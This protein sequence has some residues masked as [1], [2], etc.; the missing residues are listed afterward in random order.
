M[1][2]PGLSPSSLVP[3][4]VTWNPPPEGTTCTRVLASESAS[5]SSFRQTWWSLSFTVTSEKGA[6]P[7]QVSS[8]NCL[9]SASPFRCPQ[10]FQDAVGKRAWALE[11]DSPKDSWASHLPFRSL[12]FLI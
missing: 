1:P 8:L 2:F 9:E 6:I 11:A 3:R 12:N 4:C 7:A 5:R 10:T